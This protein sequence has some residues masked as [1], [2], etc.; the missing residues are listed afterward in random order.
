[1]FVWKNSKNIIRSKIHR[2][3][4][5]GSLHIK[6]TNIHSKVL[7]GCNFLQRHPFWQ[8]STS[9][10]QLFVKMVIIHTVF[11][12]WGLL[13]NFQSKNKSKNKCKM[14]KEILRKIQKKGWL[15]LKL[16]VIREMR[17]KW[18]KLWEEI[19]TIIGASLQGGF[20]ILYQSCQLPSFSAFYFVTQNLTHTP[21]HAHISLVC[22]TIILL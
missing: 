10:D 9:F 20:M 11:N 17:K 7:N 1:M 8:N 14:K 12:Q 3:R 22:N 16:L 6:G 4:V 21:F 13:P 15:K 2:I 5:V 19:K 18:R